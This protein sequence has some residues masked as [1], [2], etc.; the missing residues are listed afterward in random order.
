VQPRECPPGCVVVGKQLAGIALL[1]PGRCRLALPGKFGHTTVESL[2]LVFCLSVAVA[3]IIQVEL[4][5]DELVK[6]FIVAEALLFR[7]RV[8]A[9]WER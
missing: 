9:Q 2:E 5:L 7:R 8:N 1:A 3:E 4:D 6:E